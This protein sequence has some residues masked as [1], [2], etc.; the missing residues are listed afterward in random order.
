MSRYVRQLRM[1]VRI[2]GIELAVLVHKDQEYRIP[3]DVSVSNHF[4]TSFPECDDNPSISTLHKFFHTD[5]LPYRLSF[6]SEKSE[7]HGHNQ[8]DGKNKNP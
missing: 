1:T 8:T 5:T 2:F 6:K 7:P 4:T 3:I